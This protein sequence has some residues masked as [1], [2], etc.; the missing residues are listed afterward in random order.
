VAEDQLYGRKA[1][2]CGGAAERPQ[3]GPRP[4]VVLLRLRSKPDLAGAVLRPAALGG[5]L[6]V[7]AG[8]VDQGHGLERMA[9]RVEKPRTVDQDGDALRSGNRNVEAVCVEEEIDATRRSSPAE[10]ASVR[11]QFQLIA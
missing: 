4:R 11:R 1:A 8:A 5:K 6:E 2:R 10:P 7:A 3:P 9:F